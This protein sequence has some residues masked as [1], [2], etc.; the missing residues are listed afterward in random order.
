MNIDL[1]DNILIL[2]ASLGNILPWI[3]ILITLD[4]FGNLWRNY[5]SLMGH[6]GAKLNNFNAVCLI[7]VAHEGAK[8]NEPR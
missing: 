3:T 5:N 7:I 6:E 4:G 2:G 1:K 8:F